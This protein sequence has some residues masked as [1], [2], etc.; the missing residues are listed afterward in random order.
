M[1]EYL[2]GEYGVKTGNQ[3]EFRKWLSSH[4][5]FHWFVEFYGIIHDG[6]FDIVIGNPPYLETREVEYS[7]LHF[8]CGESGAIHAICVER[9]IVLNAGSGS[10]SMIVPLAL[11]STQRMQAVQS[12]LEGARSCWYSNYSWRPGKLFDTVN[13]ALTI[14]VSSSSTGSRAT[15]ATP[16]FKW[17]ADSRKFLLPTIYY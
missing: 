5:P 10:T 11:V 6:G 14:F 16:Y 7:P 12:I 4:Q 1:D 13:R 2:A 15:L 17:N 8:R 9:S 3:P